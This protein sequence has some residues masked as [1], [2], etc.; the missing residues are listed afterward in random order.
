[1]EAARDREKKQRED[2]IKTIMSAFAD[3]VVKDQ[4]AVI[5]EEDDKMMRHILDQEEK[6]RQEDER[7]AQ[8]Q[9]QQKQEMRAYLN[10]Q[11]D[12]KHNRQVQDDQINKKQAEIWAK[13]RENF[14]EH[15]NQKQDYIKMV[16]K[17]HQDILK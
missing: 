6:N 13:D 2:K 11:M 5:R 3:T 16:N 7:K 14:M 8:N 1:M 4:K 12:E 10:K 15:E 9:R 17:K